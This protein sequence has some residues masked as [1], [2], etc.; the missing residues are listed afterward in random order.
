[1]L[2]D[3]MKKKIDEV[4]KVQKRAG[5]PDDLIRGAVRDCV[6]GEYAKLM[7]ET[8]VEMEEYLKDKLS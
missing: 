6:A 3:R 8:M 2:T 5:M 4:I 1:M 7:Q